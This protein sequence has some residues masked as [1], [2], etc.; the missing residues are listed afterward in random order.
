MSFLFFF[1]GGRGGGVT[2]E[3]YKDMSIRSSFSV[4]E[5]CIRI[6]HFGSKFYRHV[7]PQCGSF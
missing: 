3:T 1:L 5:I 7:Q 4:R 2:D 6:L